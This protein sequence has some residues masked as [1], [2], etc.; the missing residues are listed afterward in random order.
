MFMDACDQA[1]LILLKMQDSKLLRFCWSSFSRWGRERC[2]FYFCHKGGQ[3]FVYFCI[4]PV[5]SPA[6]QIIQDTWPTIANIPLT[7]MFMM[8]STVCRYSI[9]TIWLPS[10]RTYTFTNQC[11]YF[12]IISSISEYDH[13]CETKNVE[14]EFGTDRC[15]QIWCNRQ[16]DRYESGLGLPSV[17]RS[18]FWTGLEPNR[19]VY[20]VQTPTA[21]RLLPPVANTIEYWRVDSHSQVIEKFEEAL[22]V[23]IPSKRLSVSSKGSRSSF[24]CP[25]TLT[26]ICWHLIYYF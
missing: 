10:H 1:P 24:K 23:L 3:Y 21:A 8:W 11:Q 12:T 2:A 6:P 9:W 16:V 26:P 25:A 18:G 4:W 17:T 15:S 14:L 7:L 19:P 13:K 20:V 5:A 22:S